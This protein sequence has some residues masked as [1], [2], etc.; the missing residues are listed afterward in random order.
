MKSPPRPPEITP[1]PAAAPP[2]DV[3]AMGAML[4]EAC[5]REMNTRA[6][7]IMTNRVL[8]ERDRRIAELEAR[9]EPVT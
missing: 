2:P 9:L 3:E 6:H 5:Q 1:A 4:I 7:L 8:A